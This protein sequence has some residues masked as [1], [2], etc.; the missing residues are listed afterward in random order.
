MEYQK[1]SHPLQQISTGEI[2]SIHAYTFTGSTSGATIYLQANLHGPEILGTAILGKLITRLEQANDIP[3]KVI[4]VPCANPIGVNAVGYNALVGRW[5]LHNG[6]NWNRIFTNHL[7]WKNLEEQKNYY[8][9][10]LTQSNLSIEKKLGATLK[11]LSWEATH[12]IDIHTAG[13]QSVPHLF[14]F[15][16]SSQIFSYLGSKVHLILTK[17]YASGAFD[18]S[19]VLPFIDTLPKDIIPKVCTWEVHN[20]SEI[21]NSVVLERFQ[22]LWNCLSYIWGNEKKLEMHEPSMFLANN[23]T[24]LV[25]P[26]AGYYSWQKQIGTNIKIDEVYATVYQPW[27]NQT[28]SIK[29]EREFI[30]LGKY[31][32]DAIAEG[33]QIGWIVYL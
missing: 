5:N 9:S 6:T 1:S 7:A 18:E 22:Q 25:A 11:L 19:H 30:L 8:Q 28:L 27:H 26:V 21:D 20:H 15:E 2:L 12:V 16:D 33:E 4:I 24:H 13:S 14:T 3:G 23:A 32:I 17:E 10:K 29:A 31:G